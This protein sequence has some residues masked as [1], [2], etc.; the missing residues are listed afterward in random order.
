MA[1]D[2][3]DKIH[4]L[5]VAKQSIAV[6]RRRRRNLWAYCRERAD[7]IERQ[8]DWASVGNPQKHKQWWVYVTGE[9]N[10]WVYGTGESN[11]AFATPP[12]CG[13]ERF[14]QLP[15]W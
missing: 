11:D 1:Y 8:V 4:G 15:D 12:F 9:S 6:K 13:E 3:I 2:S 14:N 10:W 5:L 7:S